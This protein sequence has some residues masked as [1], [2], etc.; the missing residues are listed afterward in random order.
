MPAVVEAVRLIAV[1]S[2]RMLG[3]VRPSDTKHCAVLGLD[4]TATFPTPSIAVYGLLRSKQVAFELP[5]VKKQHSESTENP[6]V[7]FSSP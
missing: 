2:E 6:K 1:E 4:P 3:P 7:H 5:S